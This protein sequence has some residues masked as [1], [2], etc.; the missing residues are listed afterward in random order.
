VLKCKTDLFVRIFISLFTTPDHTLLRIVYMVQK[1]DHITHVALAAPAAIPVHAS[2]VI[3]V[4]IPTTIL[5]TH[6]LLLLISIYF[7]PPFLLL[8]NCWTLV[9]QAVSL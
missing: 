1:Q 3:N 9:F 6:L 8:W 7:C 4:V 2:K 5:M